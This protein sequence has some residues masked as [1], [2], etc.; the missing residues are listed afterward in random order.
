MCLSFCG[1]VSTVLPLQVAE[2][3]I[4]D[5][6]QMVCLTPEQMALEKRRIHLKTGKKQTTKTRLQKKNPFSIFSIP[7]LT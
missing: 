1:G 4:Q 6:R 3:A 2:S 5:N 7:H